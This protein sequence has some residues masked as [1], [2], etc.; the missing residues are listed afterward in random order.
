MHLHTPSTANANW[1]QNIEH[2][3]TFYS[4]GWLPIEQRVEQLKLN[5]VYRVLGGTAPTY[6]SGRLTLNNHSHITRSSQSSLVIP[7]HGTYGK[8]AFCITGAK[9]WNSLPA[10]INNSPYLVNFKKKV[11]VFLHDKMVSLSVEQNEFILY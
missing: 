3:I 1:C 10:S 4:L 8:S 5:H 6:L 7:H 2:T 9:L 11:K